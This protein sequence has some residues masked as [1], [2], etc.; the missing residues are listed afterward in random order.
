MV[1]AYVSRL[2]LPLLLL[3]DQG[4]VD[5]NDIPVNHREREAW[6]DD[7]MIGNDTVDTWVVELGG[8]FGEAI[9]RY[10]NAT[11]GS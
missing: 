2:T 6:L 9:W 11:A 8:A 7:T 4:L 1:P 10:Q 3:V 5:P